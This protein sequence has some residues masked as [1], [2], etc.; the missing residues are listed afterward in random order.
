MYIHSLRNAILCLCMYIRNAYAIQSYAHVYISV[1]IPQCLRNNEAKMH[2]GVTTVHG[3]SGGRFA[4]QVMIASFG[5]LAA[6][7]A[8]TATLY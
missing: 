6:Y 5:C 4:Q 7:I 3:L 2:P 1:T 8:L